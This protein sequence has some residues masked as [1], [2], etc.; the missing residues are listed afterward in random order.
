M[1]TR[2]KL[3]PFLNYSSYSDENGK[4]LALFSSSYSINSFSAFAPG[5]MGFA[6]AYPNPI[7]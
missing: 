2:S 1:I 5:Y 3:G 7:F 6:F 4:T